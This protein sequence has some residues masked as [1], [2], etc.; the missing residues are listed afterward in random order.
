MMNFE[1]NSTHLA[2]FE[3][4]TSKMSLRMRGCVNYTLREIL[5]TTQEVVQSEVLQNNTTV[6]SQEIIASYSMKIP[7]LV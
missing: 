5:M 4:I 2:S 1:T 6:G 3:D 7:K